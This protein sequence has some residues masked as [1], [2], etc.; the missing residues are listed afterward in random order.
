MK[1]RRTGRPADY[2]DNNLLLSR[3]FIRR[4]PADA[5]R[6]LERIDPED[7]TDLLKYIPPDIS[8]RMLESMDTPEALRCLDLMENDIGAAIVAEMQHDIAAL[9]LRRLGDGK[10][11]SLMKL[12][13]E[14]KLAVLKKQLGYSRG[15]IGSAMEPDVFMVTE[16]MEVDAIRSRLKTCSGHSIEQIGRASCRERV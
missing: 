10:R 6:I 3:E 9:Y 2:M 8:G 13:P 16:D 1:S 5:A 12:L 15:S 4:H 14:G 11:E 7:V